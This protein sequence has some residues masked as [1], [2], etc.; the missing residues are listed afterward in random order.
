M[1]KFDSLEAFKKTKYWSYLISRMQSFEAEIKE[2]SDGFNQLWNHETDEMAIILKSHLM[3]E[4]YIDKYLIVSYPTITHWE[5]M[6]LTFTQKLEM[7][8][9][10]GSMVGFY[11][12][13]IKELNT[14]RNRFAHKVSYKMKPNDY[15]EIQRTTTMWAEARKEAI[16]AGNEMF[17]DF[18]LRVCNSI[19]SVL[20]GI[21]LHSEGLGLPYYLKWMKEM[22]QP[23]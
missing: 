9:Y 1:D 5:D 19:E 13:G 14:I 3:V 15:K 18:V 8:R 23:F 12:K 20:T 11:Y 7:C 21:K 22:Q 17:Y 10:E 16:P 4:Y 6:R 2:F